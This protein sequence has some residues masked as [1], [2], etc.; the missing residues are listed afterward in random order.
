[1][2]RNS[3]TEEER[4]RLVAELIA[5]GMTYDEF[6]EQAGVPK[7]NLGAWT[8]RLYREGDLDLFTFTPRLSVCPVMAR[9]VRHRDPGAREYLKAAYMEALAAFPGKGDNPLSSTGEM[10]LASISSMLGRSSPH[11]GISTEDLES[12]LE[13]SDARKGQMTLRIAVYAALG[14]GFHTHHPFFDWAA[15]NEALLRDMRSAGLALANAIHDGGFLRT[16]VVLVGGR[17]TPTAVTFDCDTPFCT[18]L[19]DGFLASRRTDARKYI[20]LFCGSFTESLGFTPAR[21]ED[22]TPATFGRQL[23]WFRDNSPAHQ[24]LVDTTLYC[25]AFYLYLL[26]LL[27]ADQT[28]FTFATGLPPRALAYERIAS[29]WLEGYRCAV[30][31]TLDPVPPWPKLLLYPTADEALKSSVNE[32]AP[33]PFDLSMGEDREMEA[34]LSR[35][36]W[37]ER[38][39][40]KTYA[41]LTHVKRLALGI[42]LGERG[43]DGSYTA[44]PLMVRAALPG[45]GASGKHVSGAKSYLRRF[46]SF[47]E[48]EGSVDVQPG[49]WLL[50]ETTG[51]ERDRK[52]AAEVGA[53]SEEDLVK[54]ARK[55]EEHAGDSL[56]DELAYVAFAVQALTDLR[57]SEICGLRVDGLDAG[58][59]DGVRAVRVCRKTSGKDFQNVQVTEEI[60]RLLKAAARITGPAR[61]EADESIAGYLFLYVGPVGKPKV[62]TSGGY[63]YRLELACGE[64]GITVVKPANIRKRYVTTVIQEGL[65]NGLS[66]LALIPITGHADMRSDEAYLRPDI[67]SRETRE[68]LEGAFLVEIGAP[69]LK[70]EVL[71]DWEL[72]AEVESLVE[73][74]AG[75]CRSAACNVAG[76]VPCPMCRGFATSPRYIPEMLDAIATIDGQLKR[77]SPHDREHLLTAKCVYLAYLGKMLDKE[78]ETEGDRDDG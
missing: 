50:L 69:D 35:W 66:R 55:L 63:A 9:T 57:A 60:H 20:T 46:L 1:M 73:G 53:V 54:L 45:S 23:E 8:T 43:E 70:G 14:T 52:D 31:E 15:E 41:Y 17:R 39:L 4:R 78:K 34:V 59:R 13:Q 56:E 40:R 12:L 72:P 37:Q 74:G 61:T 11:A 30:H 49:C 44:A 47:C 22:F 24:A 29:L 64:L 65:R 76:S 42:S 71:P 21:L 27:P 51:A 10:V 33:V 77:A 18:E 26:D 38:S 16:R 19:L 36:A 6:A 25:R 3:Y 28:A 58:P 62:L 67:M 68:Y 75:V 2:A 48:D 32:N 5:S 7:G